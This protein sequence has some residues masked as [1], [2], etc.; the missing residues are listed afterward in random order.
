MRNFVKTFGMLAELRLIQNASA[1]EDA[2]A[3][4]DGWNQMSKEERQGLRKPRIPKARFSYAPLALDPSGVR[5][6]WQEKDVIQLKHSD[7]PDWLPLKN[8][9]KVWD[10]IVSQL[11]GIKVKGY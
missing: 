10:E 7:N 3:A 6:A 1:I 9:P 5:L 4:L 11:N 8:E 2:Y